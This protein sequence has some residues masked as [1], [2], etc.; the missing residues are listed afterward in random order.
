MKKIKIIG[1]GLAGSEA[2][3]QLADAGWKVSLFE[4]RPHQTTPAHETGKFAE[5][6]CSNSFKS[7]L[8]T[9][10][11]GLLKE[12]MKLLGCKLLP[13]AE[14]CSVPAGNAL[15]V[16]RGK[17]SELVTDIISK[18]PNI[19]IIREEVTELDDELTIVATGPLT[20]AKLTKNLIELIGEEQLYF[21]DAIAPIM[22]VES[23][24]YDVVYRKTRYDKGE[25]DYLNCPFTK[26]EY[27]EFVEALDAGEKH[28]A[29][30]FEAEF[31]ADIKFR[32]YE[33]CTPIEELARRGK[34]TLRFGVM[35]PVGLEIPGTDK[36]PYAVIQ[37]RA[38]NNEN[39]SYNLVGCQTML[40]YG[41]QQRIFRLIP[42]LQN[43]E[44]LRFGSIHRNTYLN[45]PHILNP[46][47]SL[48][49]KP[50]IFI[51]GQLAGVEGY[52]ESILGGMLVARNVSKL[53]LGNER[54]LFRIPHLCETGVSQDN[55]V[56]KEGFGNEKDATEFRNERKYIELDCHI[57]R[58][59]NMQSFP[60]NLSFDSAQDDINLLPETT[61]SGQLWRHLII[62]TENFQPMNANF[63]L[64][65]SFEKKIRDKKLKKQMLAERS[66]ED[67]KKFNQS[68]K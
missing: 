45:G 53:G 57:E 49:A 58:S 62:P 7:K 56:P 8:I 29:H 13:I 34:D 63:G 40:K 50:N 51:A 43:A 41:E 54:D 68:L 16:D 55:C 39:T 1:A 10:S 33:N 26:E 67:L 44:F 18:H 28:E 24:D 25:A 32:F 42:G 31:F 27:Y 52:V 21:F 15:A 2:A 22:D 66:L 30:E 6:V 23:L 60:I 20:S 9:T 59:R 48:K 61:I 3:L 5:V 11:S 64:L 46:D 19:K 35:R 47:L 37:L 38:E 12:E 36:R 14:K 17:F 65:P 4:M